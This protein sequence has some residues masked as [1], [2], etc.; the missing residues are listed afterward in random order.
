MPKTET[1]QARFRGS[2]DVIGAM[3]RGDR[4]VPATHFGQ[5]YGYLVPVPRDETDI[6]TIARLL[7][8]AV[9]LP[10]PA[11]SVSA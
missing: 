4:I 11:E 9:G 7:R 1:N 10:E 5:A 8:Q 3:A 6:V 2:L